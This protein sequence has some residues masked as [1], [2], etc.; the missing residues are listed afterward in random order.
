[1]TLWSRAAVAVLA[2]LVPLLLRRARRDYEERGELTKSTSAIGWAGYLIHGAAVA[3]AAVRSVWRLPLPARAARSLGG[4]LVVAGAA[5]FA[6]GVSAFRSFAQMSGTS[7]KG[8]VTGGIYRYSRNPQ[9]VGGGLVLFGMAI[10][11]L[12]GF[13]LLLV[14]AFALAFRLYLR[15]EE[16]HMRRLYGTEWQRYA[17]RAP[18]VLGRPRD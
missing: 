16:E 2:L 13:A 5:I 11:G 1:M 10:A 6:A 4:V 15:S 14:A 8:L 18:R 7:N 9:N 17:A 12:S 3:H